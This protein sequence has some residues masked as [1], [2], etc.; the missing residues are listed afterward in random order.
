MQSRINLESSGYL[1]GSGL[2]LTESLRDGMLLVLVFNRQIV[3]N[4]CF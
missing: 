1:P 3:T 2:P 4:M